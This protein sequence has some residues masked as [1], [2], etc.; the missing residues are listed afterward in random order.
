MIRKKWINYLISGH[1]TDK[2]ITGLADKIADFHSQAEIVKKES[3]ADNLFR[4]FA[5][6]K[7]A[8]PFLRE[9]LSD[10]RV[11]KISDCIDG[12]Q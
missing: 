10:V 3:E 6:I 7:M 8:I 5:D 9:H 2:H 4:L 11:K 1:V 12:V